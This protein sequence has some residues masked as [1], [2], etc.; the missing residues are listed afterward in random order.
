[1]TANLAWAIFQLAAPIMGP[2]LLIL[3]IRRLEG[4]R[5]RPAVPDDW[6]YRDTDED[7]D[8]VVQYPRAVP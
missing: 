8:T 4:P 1:M 3:V 6:E 7:E 5:P 2:V